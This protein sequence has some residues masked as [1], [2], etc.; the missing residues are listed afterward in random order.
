MPKEALGR[1]ATS[2]H[3]V[4]SFNG[5]LRDEFLNRELFLSMEEA[6]W[7]LDRWQLG[8]NHRCIH[9]AL[10]YQTPAA[11]ASDCGPPASAAPQPPEHSRIT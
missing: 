2:S 3:L 7:V 10:D 9:G 1:T 8:Y 11:Y 4:E 5:K 6:R